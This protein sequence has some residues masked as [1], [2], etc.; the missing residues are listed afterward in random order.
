MSEPTLGMLT[1]RLER[2]ERAHRR[3]KRLGAGAL[4]G[5]AVVVLMGQALPARRDI[6]AQ[7]FVLLD[8]TGHAYA[9]LGMFGGGPAL[10]LFDKEGR[11][12]AVLSVGQNGTPLLSLLDETRKGGAV[13]GVGANQDAALLLR[14]ADGKVRANL[15]LDGNGVTFALS[16]PKGV[17]RVA[18]EAQ[19][20]ESARLLLQDGTGTP[21]AALASDRTGAASL[22]VMD[23]AGRPRAALASDP[24]G[25]TLTLYDP[26]GAPR[27]LLGSAELKD[28]SRGTTVQRPAA[29]LLLFREDGTVLW[30]AP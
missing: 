11:G 4:A 22:R 8:P 17:T 20:V 1:Q 23:Q 16:D 25:P 12:R 7:S 14:D 30:T 24:V 9:R 27:A 3:W 10:Q 29:S 21:R 2:L 13:L 5:I 6:E 28:A 26:N 19:G 15:G 18:I